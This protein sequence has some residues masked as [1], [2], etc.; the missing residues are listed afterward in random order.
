MESLATGFGIPSSA[1]LFLRERD[2]PEWSRSQ[3]EQDVGSLVASP[4]TPRAGPAVGALGATSPPC[5]LPLLPLSFLFPALLVG[6][7]RLSFSFTFVSTAGFLCGFRASFLKCW[8][9][10]VVACWVQSPEGAGDAFVPREV[11]SV[12]WGVADN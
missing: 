11:K 12:P 5:P 4:A 8:Q 2:V 6:N 7:G 1:F 9:G 3:R 10:L